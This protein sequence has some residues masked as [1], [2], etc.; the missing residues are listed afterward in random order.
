MGSLCLK[1]KS[2]SGDHDQ[3]YPELIETDLDFLM[4]HTG[5]TEKEVRERH[6]GMWR[7]LK[8]NA[9]TPEKFIELFR[10]LEMF[11]SFWKF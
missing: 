8:T 9:L 3:E 4:R 6:L 11:T 2:Y 1:P 7:K 10:E 5:L